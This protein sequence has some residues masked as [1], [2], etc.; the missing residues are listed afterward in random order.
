MKDLSLF[1]NKI[2]EIRG[3]KVMLDFDLATLYEVETKVLN[4]AVKRNSLRFPDDFMFQI[5]TE[6][7]ELNWSQFV[8]SSRKHRG[9]VYLPFA[10]TE[11][12]VA[13]LS[14]VLRSERAILV[15]IA[16]MRAFVEIRKIITLQ[17]H[18][19]KQFMNLKVDLEKRL[20]EHDIQFS[21]VYALLEQFL[22]EK[23]EKTDWDNRK[24]LG[25]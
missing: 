21:E 6:E 9:K 17:S 14:S 16:I 7:L 23:K 1:Q 22:D 5:T 11:Q 25:F 10:F 24:K 12:G 18:F 19:D 3:V 13:M 2:Y 8:T 20:G 15:N 4:Q